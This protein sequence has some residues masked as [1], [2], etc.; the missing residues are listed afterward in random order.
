M[1]NEIQVNENTIFEHQ[2]V[3][4]AEV[5]ELDKKIAA[6][7][8]NATLW[9]ERGLLLAKLLLFPESVEA[10]S[11]AIAIAPFQGILYR[12]R[13]H[14]MLSCMRFAEACSDFSMAS[15]LIPDNWD[16]WYHY[17]LSYFLLG[18]Y[19]NARKIYEVGYSQSDS[20]DKLIAITD[21]LWITLNRLGETQLAAEYLDK[22][23]PDFDPGENG[24]Y[25]QRLMM[26]KGLVQP[27]D[28]L[29][30]KDKEVKLRVITTGFGLANYYDV[31]GDRK[32]SDEIID[33]V[34][35]AGKDNFYFAFGYLAAMTDKKKRLIE[36]K[37]RRDETD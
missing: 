5:I 30:T 24:N 16:V 25:F 35:D 20:Q 33:M 2:N 22:I 8:N 4:P 37:K 29:P 12:H 15:R 9:L 3:L 11:K 21:W 26:Y 17:G 31:L 23:K 13:G 14:R 27:E 32:K 18:D 10:Y 1:R 6:D 19:I 34:L 7:P 28:L 36:A